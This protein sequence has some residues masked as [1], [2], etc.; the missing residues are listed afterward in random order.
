MGGRLENQKKGGRK[1]MIKQDDSCSVCGA[2]VQSEKITY[3]QERAGKVYLVVDVPALVC[4]QCGEQ[5]L[6]PETVDAMQ[7][8]IDEG[9]AQD[10]IEVP[11]YHFPSY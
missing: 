3:T 8:A 6:T 9:K 7:E 1:T 10:K 5:Y 11:V 4:P 2:A